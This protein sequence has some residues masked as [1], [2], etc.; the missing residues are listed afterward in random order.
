[1]EKENKKLTE[2]QNKV[3]LYIHSKPNCTQANMIVNLGMKPI[4]VGNAVKSL[5]QLKL[6]KE[7]K[8]PDGNTFEA[9][10]KPA[11]KEKAEKVK[12]EKPKAE[13]A[14]KPK[15]EKKETPKRIRSTRMPRNLDKYELSGD[16][17]KL[18]KGRFVWSLVKQ[19]MIDNPKATYEQLCEA[20]PVAL[21][22]GY[23]GVFAKVADVKKQELT[24][25]YFMKLDQL[26]KTADGV[27]IAVTM[28]FGKGNI[29]VVLDHAKKLGYK[30]KV[31]QDN[32]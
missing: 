1:M 31:H 26:I 8:A 2:T 15:A 28:E 19:Y 22:K 9:I 29:Q 13:K 17:K 11:A 24:A 23:K 4:V 16:G 7:T 14:E 3:L 5:K 30:V 25:R 32:G 10:V 18:G 6:I 27:L 12:V 20:F 21:Q